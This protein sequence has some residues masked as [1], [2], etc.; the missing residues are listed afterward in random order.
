MVAGMPIL[1]ELAEAGGTSVLYGGG[2]RPV[3][4]GRKF[5]L[6]CFAPRVRLALVQ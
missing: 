1:L 3:R 5:R 6:C 2:K 4:V